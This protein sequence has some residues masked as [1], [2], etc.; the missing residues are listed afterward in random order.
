MS[1]F[2]FYPDPKHLELL[3]NIENVTNGN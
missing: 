3:E 1:F 2:I